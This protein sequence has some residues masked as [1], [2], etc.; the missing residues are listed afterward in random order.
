MTRRW[1]DPRHFG[2]RSWRRTRAIY[3]Y[4]LATE[5]ERPIAGIGAVYWVAISGDFIVWRDHPS[6]NW[7]IF[8]YDLSNPVADF[9]A[10]PARRAEMKR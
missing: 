2:G 10:P 9:C 1:H 7:D 4:D 6:G 5:T 3:L 8:L